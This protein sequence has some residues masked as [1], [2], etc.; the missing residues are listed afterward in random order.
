MIHRNDDVEEKWVVAPIDT[1]FSK[2]RDYES[3]T[4]SRKVL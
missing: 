4:L 3:S 2:E 1:F